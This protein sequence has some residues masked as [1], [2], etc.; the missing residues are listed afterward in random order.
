[1]NV[2]GISC[3]YHDAAAALVRDGTVIAAAEEERFTR[4]KHDRSFPA[5]AIRFCLE[6]GGLQGR[7]LDLVVF[8]EKPLRKL[9]RGLQMA[10][11]FEKRFRETARRHLRHYVHQVA[12]LPQLLAD[13]TGYSGE[14]QYC[15]HHLSHAAS[16]F[17]VSPF[18]DAAVL[19]VDGVGEWVST[20]QFVGNGNRI[21]AVREMHYPQSLGMYYA[22]L[23][24]YLGFEVNEGEY[25]VMGLA[26][27]G[28]PTYQAEFARL[29]EL[30]PDGSFRLDLSCF[31]Y[32][33]S[34]DSMF[35]PK[36]VELLGPPRLPSERVEQRHM[37]IAASLQKRTEEALLG[38]VRSL[39][40]VSGSRNLCMAGGVAHNVVANSAIQR[41]GLFDQIFIQP[42][43]GDNGGAAGAAL[44]GYWR[45]VPSSRTPPSRYDTCLGPAFDDEAV[46]E[47]LI[48]RQL[49]FRR[50]SA[51]ELCR[52]VAGLLHE[53]LVVAWF[54]G[55][56]EFGPRAL[57]QRSILANPCN[58]KMKDMLNVRVKLREEFRPFAPIVTEEDIRTFYDQPTP[59]PYMLYAPRVKP[60]MEV[61][62]PA[63]VHVDGTSRTQTVSKEQNALLHC[64]LK[65]FETL[66]G[67]PVLIN[68][69]FNIGGEPIVCTPQDAVRCFLGTDIDYLAMGSF[70]VEKAF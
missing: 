39:R 29:L 13:T 70:L 41:A 57:G 50:L 68:T 6:F 8:Y 36:L 32:V 62:V 34:L 56:M 45:S 22:A 17:Y 55:R 37:D 63:S 64:L 33:H 44:E 5:N 25:K 11:P 53:D 42:A 51:G 67:V 28:Q 7:D 9:Q 27:Y 14:M 18:E 66:S 4:R 21:E 40:D 69:S 46:E 16:C 54:Q 47:V 48:S 31:D 20:G 12:T 35:S 26:S 38:L 60:G 3:Y 65:E 58:P 52:D 59:S 15:E 61:R 10:A 49:T 24:A 1:M 43:A 30:D 23:T 19:T 2:L